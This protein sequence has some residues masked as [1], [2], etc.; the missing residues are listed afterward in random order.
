LW[1]LT[2]SQNRLTLRTRS[3]EAVAFS[4]DARTLAIG[5]EGSVGLWSVD[6]P[7]PAR[8]I[9]DICAAVDTDLTPLERS[10]YLHDQSRET[11]C[12]RAAP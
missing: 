12:R 11:G 2:T 9:N 3:P 6:L 1:D 10:R 5:V 7:E 8:A 4:P